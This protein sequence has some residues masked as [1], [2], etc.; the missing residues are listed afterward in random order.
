MIPS[1]RDVPFRYIGN[2]S[3]SIRISEPSSAASL[4]VPVYI[5]TGAD[6]SLFDRR[7]LARL[8]VTGDPL[9]L[10]RSGAVAAVN[11]LQNSLKCASLCWIEATSS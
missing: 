1:S 4:V 10:R 7:I 6:R 2:P 3:L 8:G 9:R 11:S 5:D